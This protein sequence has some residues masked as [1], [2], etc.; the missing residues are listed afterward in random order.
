MK[1]ALIIYTIVSI[2]TA[3]QNLMAR[4]EV[5]EEGSAQKPAQSTPTGEA[6]A[7]KYFRKST[8]QA[9]SRSY[10]GDHYLAVHLGA[11]I[12]SDSYKW[13][14]IDHATNNGR[15][16]GGFTYR[17]GSFGDFSDFALRADV[18]GYEVAD[19][20]PV[21]IAVLPMILLPEASSEFPLYFG[22]GIGAGFFFNQVRE[23]SF[24]SLNY[25]IVA[26][27]RFFNALDNVGF[28]LEGG[29]KNNL[30]LMT[31]GQFIGYFL[32]I[33]SLFTF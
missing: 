3:S 25:Q 28:F 13:G 33:G 10:S 17:M 9:P 31:D 24:I 18:I 27:A 6:E 22:G 2:L 14:G 15:I 20:R 12:S 30:L 16:N 21:Q 8:D 19:V 4:T 26:G 32:A 1:K 23:E 29:L 5:D 11:F 7:R